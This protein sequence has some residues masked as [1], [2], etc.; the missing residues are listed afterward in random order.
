MVFF[1]GDFVAP[2]DAFLEVISQLVG[3]ASVEEGVAGSEDVQE[4]ALGIHLSKLEDPKT[5]FLN[6]LTRDPN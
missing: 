5:R 2:L 1:A 4:K 6:T 3:V